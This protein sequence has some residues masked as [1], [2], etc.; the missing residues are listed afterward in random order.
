MVLGLLMNDFVTVFVI[1][2]DVEWDLLAGAIAASLALIVSVSGV[3]LRKKGL[4]R[5]SG[6]F[7][8][9]PELGIVITSILLIGLSTVFIRTIV[10]SNRLVSAY[11]HGEYEVVEGT[12]VVVHVQPSGGHDRG[13]IVCIGRDVFTINYFHTTPGYNL[14]ITHGGA[15]R[16]GVYARVYH[17]KGTI[18]RIDIRKT[19]TDEDPAAAEEN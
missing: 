17:K 19:Q 13:D 14:T 10:L 7:F 18:M 9:S 15:L 16:D 6:V 2:K 5:G 11:E 3:I 8:R 12:A 4:I 1:P